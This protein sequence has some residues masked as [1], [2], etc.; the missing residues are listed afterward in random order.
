MSIVKS[1]NRFILTL[2]SVLML[3]SCG[4]DSVSA[5]KDEIVVSPS[6]IELPA[7]SGSSSVEVISNCSWTVELSSVDGSDTSWLVL[8][9]SRGTGNVTVSFRVLENKYKTERK[10]EILFKTTNGEETSVSVVQSGDA[11][12]EEVT[13]VTIRVGS[14]NI[15]IPSTEDQNHETRNW[16]ARKGFL[17]SSIEQCAFDVVGLQE[18]SSAQQEDLK[19]K[20]AGI[21]GMHFF[22]P[23]SRDGKGDRAQGVMYRSNI[24]NISDIHFFWIGPDPDSMTTID[25]DSNGTKY[26]RGGF[27]CVL[28]HKASGIKVFFMN[29]HGCLNKDV[30]AQY[31]SVFEQMEKRYNTEGLPAFLVGDMNATPDHSMMKTI[32]GYWTDSYLKAARKTGIANT[33]NSWTSPNGLRRIDYVLYRNASAPSLYCCDNTLFNNNYPSDHFPVYADFAIEK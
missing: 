15:R 33:F 2:T 9:K 5:V 31:A 29:T 13:S 19:S 17:W 24:F 8:A 16:D 1:F 20:W 10:A 30:G 27:C 3:S 14:Y 26:N 28:T 22:S 32:T 25:V 7:S 12:A 4:D 21:Y 18:V 6:S 23:Y 11:S